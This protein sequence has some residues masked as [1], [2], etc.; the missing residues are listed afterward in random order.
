MLNNRL[1]S[2]H[3]V[4]ALPRLN[5]L[6]IANRIMRQENYMIALLNK[7]T[8][9][10]TVPLP[11]LLLLGWDGRQ[12]F[13]QVLQWNLS[14]CIGDYV[15]AEADQ[16]REH[17]VKKEFLNDVDRTALIAGLR[18][19]FILMSLV[20]LMLAPFIFVTLILFSF[21]KYGE[22]CISSVNSPHIQE[23]HK[24]P[25]M[26]SSRAY[27]EI[28]KWKFRD[29]NELEHLYQRRLNASYP[30]AMRYINQF[31]QYKLAII[32]KFISFVSGS[33]ALA[34]TLMSIVDE[35]VLISF[36]LTPGRSVLWYLGILGIIWTAAR[37]FVPDRTIP[38]YS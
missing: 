37:A 2:E 31:P 4:A 10:M 21:F 36:H 20:N 9:D 32:A 33:L 5:A 17:C 11:R 7:D 38:V 30:K 16:G 28:A 22:V 18:R 29:F 27:S 1:R 8:L 24:N 35:D 13:T 6:D 34:L 14:F 19:R 23:F 25:T 3:S 12:M 26:L 15:F